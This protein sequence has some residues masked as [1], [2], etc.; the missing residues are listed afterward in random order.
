MILCLNLQA[1]IFNA[2]TLH[3][4]RQDSVMLDAGTGYN[5]YYW[6]TGE[7]TQTI[8]A[9]RS[10][11]YFVE[12]TTASSTTLDSILIDLNRSRIEQN[13]TTVC[14]A[15]DFVISVANTEPYSLIGNYPFDN[16]EFKDYSGYGNNAFSALDMLKGTDRHGNE[17]MALYLSP[18]TYTP[19]SL[20]CV[21][22][23]YNDMFDISNSFAIHCWVKPDTIFGVNAPNNMYYL[24]NRWKPIDGNYSDCSYALALTKDGHVIFLTSDGSTSQKF[25]T[26]GDTLVHPGRWSAIDV[27][28]SMRKIKIYVNS[29]LKVNADI[30]VFP[31]A[32]NLVDTYIGASYSLQNHNYQGYIDDVRIY[33]SDLSATEIRNLY[34]ENTTYDYDYK[35]NTGET[36][37][38]ITINPTKDSQHIVT[39]S[40]NIGYCKDTV[41]IAVHP[42]L[43][44]KVTQIRKGCP[45][46]SE[47]ILLTSVDGG[48]PFDRVDTLLYDY[49]WPSGY[50]AND[51]ILYRLPQ[52]EYKITVTDS[53][54]CTII[55][56]AKVET[57]PRLE[58]QIV[59]EPEEIYS[60]NPTVHFSTTSTCDT[61]YVY[62]YLWKFYKL[63]NVDF[64]SYEDLEVDFNFGQFSDTL[65]SSMAFIVSHYQ[66]Y[67]AGC[68]DSVTLTIP[69]IKPQLK[70]PTAFSPNGDGINDTFD[71]TVEGHE[72]KLL[73]DIFLGNTLSIYNRQGYMVYT[74]NDYSGSP[75]EFDGKNLSDGVYFYVLKCK[76]LKKD[77]VYQGYIHIFRNLPKDRD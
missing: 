2:D 5:S 29:V 77:E 57:Y 70:I 75:G 44:V 37:R 31:Q 59:A 38:D 18:S 17:N 71:I 76:G 21:Q 56:E 43:N 58:L 11:W 28:C 42:E 74:M 8:W 35:W 51:S 64:V 61:C 39:I 69:V 22:I 65:E 60:H 1:Q 14:Y 30:S 52:G 20:S 25:N 32:L 49:T 4:C 16:A 47:G 12:A 62:E 10:A 54:G 7:T 50:Y 13:D 15:A 63:N 67:E 45:D 46:T 27:V 48:V 26:T 68:I 40:N 41:N 9:K 19:A 66:T 6:N 24:V 72:D 73:S 53:V 34:N 23:P 36:T 33:S 55:N 3:Y